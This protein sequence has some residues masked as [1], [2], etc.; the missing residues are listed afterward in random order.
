MEFYY[1]IRKNGNPLGAYWNGRNTYSE[2]WV[3]EAGKKVYN[4]LTMC[5]TDAVTLAKYYCSIVIVKRMK[6]PNGKWK[7]LPLK[8]IS[9]NGHKYEK[10]F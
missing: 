3:N 1:Q 5:M 6:L 4:N 2:S 7:E 9:K 10:V 8:V